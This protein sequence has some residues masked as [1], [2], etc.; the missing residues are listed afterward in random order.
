M[1]FLYKKQCYATLADA[2]NAFFTDQPY[3]TN[4]PSTTTFNVTS[5]VNV[6][7]TWYLRKSNYNSAGVMTSTVDQPVPS[8]AYPSCNELSVDYFMDGVGIADA[9]FSAIL[10]FALI[11]G[12]GQGFKI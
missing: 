5:F 1:G 9:I 10:I 7:G 3:S 8:V 4:T 2:N 12:F 6:S 11:L